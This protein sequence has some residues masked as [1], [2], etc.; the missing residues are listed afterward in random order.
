MGAYRFE[1]W[2]ASDEAPDGYAAWAEQAC[3]APSDAEMAAMAAAYERE[4]ATAADVALIPADCPFQP[5]Y[6]S[7]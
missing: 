6:L 1:Q 4:Q 3:P 2:A 7:H 5:V